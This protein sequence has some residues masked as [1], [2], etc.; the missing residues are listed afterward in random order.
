MQYQITNRSNKCVFFWKQL[1]AY[2]PEILNTGTFHLKINTTLTKQSIGWIDGR[3]D[4]EDEYMGW[5]WTIVEL[6]IAH[7]RNIV[8]AYSPRTIWFYISSEESISAPLLYRNRIFPAPL[9]IF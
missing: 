9:L 8:R 4:V 7:T 6:V 3:T 5:K 2:H 1:I